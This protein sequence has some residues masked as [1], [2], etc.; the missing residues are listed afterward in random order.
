MN[1]SKNEKTINNGINSNHTPMM[2][3]HNI[4]LKTII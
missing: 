4:C 1:I 3:R 2:H